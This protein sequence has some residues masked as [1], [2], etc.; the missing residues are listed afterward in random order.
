M[1]DDY[2]DDLSDEE[3]EEGFKSPA[4]DALERLEAREPPTDEDADLTG[5]ILKRLANRERVPFLIVQDGYIFGFECLSNSSLIRPNLIGYD[6]CRRTCQNSERTRRLDRYI[7]A[8]ELDSEGV[9][10]AGGM[11][12]S[13]DPQAYAE[14]HDDDDGYDWETTNQQSA[15]ECVIERTDMRVYAAEVKRLE[16]QGETVETS[17]LLK[18]YKEQLGQDTHQGNIKNADREEEKVRQRVWHAFEAAY[19]DMEGKD[20]GTEELRFI[21]ADFRKHLI[22]G[23]RCIYT[24]PLKFRFS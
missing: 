9:V 12:Y 13:S 14:S 18:F 1:S 15:F 22:R 6:Y 16:G 21:A 2:D 17:E 19:E 10:G 11:L 5:P 23:R 20:T 24:G 7:S 4:A 8:F 3:I